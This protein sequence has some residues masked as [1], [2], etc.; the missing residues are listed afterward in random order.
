LQK[1]NKTPVVDQEAENV[2]SENAASEKLNPL[3]RTPSFVWS[4][5]HIAL[6]R[7]LLSSIDAVV[8]DWAHSSVSLADHLNNSDHQIFISNTVHVLSQ[9]SD[10]LIMAC[11]GLLPLLAAATTP[12]NELD[13]ADST[14]QNLDVSVAAEFLKKFSELSDVFILVSGIGFNELEQEKNM[15]NGGILRQALRLGKVIR[16]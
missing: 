3:Y 12:N 8:Q 11:G 6:L 7:D 16:S 10:S 5:V 2:E 14:Q 13:I 1:S 4:E 15:P 9:L